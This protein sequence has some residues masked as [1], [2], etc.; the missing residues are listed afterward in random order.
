LSFSFTRERRRKREIA[1]A[2]RP[3]FGPSQMK[4]DP[5]EKTS[6]VII[7]MEEQ[8]YVI[9]SFSLFYSWLVSLWVFSNDA[10]YK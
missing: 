4:I 1:R 9:G 2:P 7:P 6:S 5:R 8:L 3:I 10:V